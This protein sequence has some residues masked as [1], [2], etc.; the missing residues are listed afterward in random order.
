MCLPTRRDLIE[1]L[2]HATSL[3]VFDNSP[4]ADPAAGAVPQP[5]LVLEVRRG[6]IVAVDLTPTPQLAEPIV[7]TAMR[8]FGAV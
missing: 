5:R 3:R 6:K 4:E 8:Q 1:L 2:P 7:V